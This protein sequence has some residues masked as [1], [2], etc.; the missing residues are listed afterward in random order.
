MSLKKN[1]KKKISF[2]PQRN[3]QL[4]QKNIPK[5]SEISFLS[6]KYQK[7]LR[8]IQNSPPISERVRGK[9]E[10]KRFENNFRMAG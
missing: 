7:Y 6:E 8:A 3:Q 1:I 4:I 10:K 9:T 5:I 2:L